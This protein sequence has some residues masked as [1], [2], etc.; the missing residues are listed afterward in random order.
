MAKPY[1]KG[2]NFE[3]YVKRKLEAKGYLV[4]RSAGSKGVFDLVAIPPTR[5]GF[6]PSCIILG[7]QCKAHGKISQV[8]KQK[9]IETAKKY[10]VVPILATKFNKRVI[11]VNLE[12]ET[13]LEGL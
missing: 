13:L 8:E 10:N 7:I 5:E 6:V 9:I 1:E 2:K 11:L 12:T 4:A 3:N